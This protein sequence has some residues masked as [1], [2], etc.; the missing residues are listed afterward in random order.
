MEE[1]EEL[2]SEGYDLEVVPNK[3]SE[4]NKTGITIK[5]TEIEYLEAHKILKNFFRI[6]GQK[7]CINGVDLRIVDLPK[8][9]IKVEV[10]SKIGMSG[11]INLNIYDVN[12]RGGA[13]MMIQK[14]SGEKFVHVKVFGIKV[15]KFLID[16]IIKGNI[17]EE[18]MEKYKVKTVKIDDKIGDKSIVNCDSCGESFKTAQRLKM[19][20]KKIH[21]DVQKINC[22]SCEN[23][24]GSIDEL[25]HHVVKVH[26]IIGSPESKKLR[27]NTKHSKEIEIQVCEKDFE[28]ENEQKLEVEDMEIDSQEESEKLSKL[29]DEK[30]LQRQ[31][32]IDKQE[33]MEKIEAGK[34][35]K[36]EKK[37]DEHREE[38]ENFKKTKI[39]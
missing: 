7:Y 33:E 16:G 28:I 4:E 26:E 1:I 13:T 19:H 34:K 5:G 27:M 14:V 12:N 24:F 11:R 8:K 30:I 35:I 37:T 21:A 3:A 2:M 20:I 15:I 36:E 39:K 29:R 23:S 25:N 17:N 22:E 18:S 10:K 9:L 31:K 6:R 38:E 32:L